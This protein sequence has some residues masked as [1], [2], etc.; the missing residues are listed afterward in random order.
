MKYKV[1]N[2]ERNRY[3]RLIVMRR[4]RIDIA[5]RHAD[6]HADRQILHTCILLLKIRAK[7]R[8]QIFTGERKYFYRIFF[9]NVIEI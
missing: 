5:D 1:V 6:R 9:L 4:V 7:N 8:N 3:T 2:S